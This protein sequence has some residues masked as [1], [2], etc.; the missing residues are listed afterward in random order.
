MSSR[1]RADWLR[2]SMKVAKQQRTGLYKPQKLLRKESQ[3]TVR[4]RVVTRSYSQLDVASHE[5]GPSHAPASGAVLTGV[6]PD[7]LG[8]G[9][10]ATH[11]VPYFP[12]PGPPSFLQHGRQVL[13]ASSRTISHSRSSESE[14]RG[15]ACPAMHG[16]AQEK[17]T[18]A[19]AAPRLK[20]HLSD[21]IR[22]KK[23]EKAQKKRDRDVDDRVN[24]NNVLPEDRR[25]K[26]DPPG[27]VEVI[28]RV[29]E[30]IPEIRSENQTLRRRN[31]MLEGQMDLASETNSV[32]TT[33]L[34]AVDTT[35][36]AEDER[37]RT[38]N[39]LIR[40]EAEIGQ[41]RAQVAGKGVASST[42]ERSNVS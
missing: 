18:R 25:V 20:Q 21:E 28:R 40:L 5:A 42:S 4:D 26:T 32:L 30:Y 24:L 38:R 12:M 8:P 10:Q 22:K 31:A 15:S 35:N 1:E 7:Y 39:L 17:A 41:L 16:R 11:S 2:R 34:H 36:E 27:L 33:L 13:A 29:T 3:S 6:P 9:L 23:A 14:T 37:T 19:A